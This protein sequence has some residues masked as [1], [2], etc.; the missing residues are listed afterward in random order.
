MVSSTRLASPRT[1]CSSSRSAAIP[2]TTR[3]P[4]QRMRA[5]HALEPADQGLVAGLEEHDVGP[6]APGLEVA[7]DRLQVG[8]ERAAAHVDDRGD[9]GHSALG[10][11]RRDPGIVGSRSGGRLSA[12]NQSRSSRDFAAVLR[13][14]PDIP[15]MMT[16]S[17]VLPCPR[18]PGRDPASRPTSPADCRPSLCSAGWS[19]APGCRAAA[20][21]PAMRGPMPGRP[22]ISSTLAPAIRRTEPKCRSSVAFLAGPRPGNGVELT[23][24]EGRRPLFLWYVIANR[25]ASSRTRCS[26]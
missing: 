1:P 19:P 3:P 2:S 17:G 6:G 23:G 7:D 16:I 25:C 4:P 12:T 14:A 13:P 15:V 24:G 22:A 10:P 20:I 21:V 18:P 9:P 26:R 8:A 11:P 5:A